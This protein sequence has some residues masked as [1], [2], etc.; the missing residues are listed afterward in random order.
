M[1]PGPAPPL[2]VDFSD[3]REVLGFGCVPMS[4]VADDRVD[5]KCVA[6]AYSNQKI[7]NVASPVPANIQISNAS[8]LRDIVDKLWK[9]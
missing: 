6:A 1:A 9:G 8:A 5:K 7:V 2:E 3:A 4:H